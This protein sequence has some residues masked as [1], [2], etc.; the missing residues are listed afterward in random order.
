M[1][2][3]S[4]VRPAVLSNTT[5]VFRGVNTRVVFFFERLAPR[6]LGLTKLGVGFAHDADDASITKRLDGVTG[7]QRL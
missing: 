1:L 6:C 7:V 4:G 2:F 3:S 5:P